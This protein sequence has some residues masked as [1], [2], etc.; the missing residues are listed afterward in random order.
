MNKTKPITNH[1]NTGK[2]KIK[3]NFPGKKHV[4]PKTKV[5]PSRKRGLISSIKIPLRPSTGLKKRKVRLPTNKQYRRRGDY[6][7]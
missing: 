1:K 6:E 4:H 3:K 7:F 2:E 5:R